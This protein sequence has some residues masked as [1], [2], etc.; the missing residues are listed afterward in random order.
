MIDEGYDEQFDRYLRRH[1]ALK[2]RPA[3]RLCYPGCQG[4]GHYRHD[5]LYAIDWKDRRL[6]IVIPGIFL[7]SGEKYI[8]KNE[9][10]LATVYF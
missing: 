8:T 7:P 5:R 4:Q 1:W 9:A 10:A 2:Q 6:E 3:A